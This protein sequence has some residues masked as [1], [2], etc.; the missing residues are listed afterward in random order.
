M[1][2]VQAYERDEFKCVNFS[3]CDNFSPEQSEWRDHEI[4]KAHQLSVNYT[5]KKAMEK[6][7]KKKKKALEHE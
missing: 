2:Q 1:S 7:E 3:L 4:L 5:I 6:K